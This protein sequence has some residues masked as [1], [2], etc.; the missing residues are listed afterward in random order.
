MHLPELESVTPQRMTCVFLHVPKTAG[1]TIHNLLIQHF[2]PE[3]ICPERFDNIS[4]YTPN[5][6]S[7]FKLFSAHACFSHLNSIPGPKK[8][9]SIFREPVDRLI[10][11]Y[12]FWHSHSSA[13]IEETHPDTLR[14]IKSNDLKAYLQTAEDNWAFTFIDNM[15]TRLLSHPHLN[16]D[17]QPWRDDAEMLDAA[18]KNLDQ[19]DAFG[20]FEFLPQSIDLMCRTFDMALPKQIEKQNVTRDNHVLNP[21]IF[22][23]LEPL[24]IDEETEALFRHR[25]RLDA[26]IYDAAKEKFFN[27]LGTRLKRKHVGLTLMGE[28]QHRYHFSTVNAAAN[29]S[30]VLLYGPYILLKAG[31]Y[32]ASVEM[33]IDSSITLAAGNDPVGYMDVCSSTGKIVHAT[34]P[35]FLQDLTPGSYIK[36]DLLF[37]LEK[38]ATELEIR[39]F[40]HGLYPLSV[41]LETELDVIE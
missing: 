9:F 29:Q 7:G 36:L 13:F 5:E 1:T 23:P 20:I 22:D 27:R 10:S 4:S 32:C 11:Q 19:L 25:C 38:T 41:K 35:I 37:T 14:D 34:R 28:I 17:G 18:L 33:G 26:I 30:G 39:V 3:E 8:I 40:S 15:T 24:D 2:K 21:S 31:K 6:I 16:A 12:Q